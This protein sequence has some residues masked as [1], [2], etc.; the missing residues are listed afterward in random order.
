MAKRKLFKF[1]ALDT[2]SNV[3]QAPFQ[4]KEDFTLKG[5]WNTDFFKNENPIVLE[6][7]CGKGEYTIALAQKHADKNFIGMDLKG[8]RIWMGAKTAL[9][10]NLLNTAFIRTHIEFIEKFFTKDEVSEIWITF[11]D[12]QPNKPR[13]RK[14]LTSPNFLNRYKNIIKK[15]GIIHLKTDNSPL[16]DYTLEVIEEGK[17]NLLFNS[18]DLYKSNITDDILTVQTHYEKL[19]T[20]KGFTINYIKFKLNEI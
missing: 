14:R 13:I 5:K 7:G 18:S 11:P 3:F 2:F 10:N 15:S 12:P 16:Y 1:A 9:E 4:D 20:Q 17:H 19:F 6:L 8:D